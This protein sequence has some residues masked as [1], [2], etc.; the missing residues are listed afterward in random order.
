MPEFELTEPSQRQAPALLR[1]IEPGE[2]RAESDT[3]SLIEALRSE[4][5]GY[6]AMARKWAHLEPDVVL[7]ELSAIT[8]RLTEVRAHLNRDNGQR[9]NRLRISEIDPLLEECDRQFKIH[10]RLIAMH[11]LDWEVARGQM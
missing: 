6:Y 9:A 10:S 7:M 2:T 1:A 8:A 11:Q 4:L 3:R 5:D